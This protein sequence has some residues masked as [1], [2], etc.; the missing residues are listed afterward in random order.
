MTLHNIVKTWLKDNGYTGLVLP[1]LECGCSLDNFMPC[2]E[3]GEH[4]K[5]GYRHKNGLMYEDK[6]EEEGE[7]G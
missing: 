3:P 1:C 5:A 7:E 2:G 4:C 6:E